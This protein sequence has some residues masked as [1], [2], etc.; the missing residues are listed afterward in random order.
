MNLT[1]HIL[2]LLVLFT[3]TAHSAY[4]GSSRSTKSIFKHEKTDHQ[5]LDT[6]PPIRLEGNLKPSNLENQPS[7]GI[8][9]PSYGHKQAIAFVQKALKGKG[10]RI[11]TI[12]QSESE[13]SLQITKTKQAPLMIKAHRI[14]PGVWSFYNTNSSGKP[15]VINEDNASVINA[16]QD[17][18]NSK[19]QQ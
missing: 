18:T 8:N 5:K 12:R 17:A 4:Q 1:R 19:M 6:T 10:Y 16:L 15:L 2:V 7:Y 3:T 14:R 9:I 13:I 11:R